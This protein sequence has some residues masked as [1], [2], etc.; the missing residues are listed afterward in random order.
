MSNRYRLPAAGRP[1]CAAACVNPRIYSDTCQTPI[2]CLLQNAEAALLLVSAGG[3]AAGGLGLTRRVH[4]QGSP[5]GFTR[6]V[7]PQG[8]P[9]G[10]TLL[11]R[12]SP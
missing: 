9:A 8:S 1:G 12:V 4:P 10:F 5:A 7:H 3:S 11:A 6:R 2:A